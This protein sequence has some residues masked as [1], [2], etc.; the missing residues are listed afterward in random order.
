MRVRYVALAVVAI[1]AID[2]GRAATAQTLT[3]DAALSQARANAPQL[4]AARARI[5][6]ARARLLGASARF[7]D[8]PVFDIDAGPRRGASQTWDI[9]A[10]FGQVFETGGQ[11]GARIAGAE[12]EIVAASA[13]ADEALRLLTREVAIAYVRAVAAQERRRL[14]ADAEA[15]ANQ[16]LQASQRRYEAG[17]IAALDLNLTRIAAARARAELA[18]S[19]ADRSDALRPLRIALGLSA[20]ADVSLEDVLDR[21]PAPAPLLMAA[22][23]QA[24]AIRQADAEIEQTRADQ[25]LGAALKRPDL[26]ARLSVSREQDD[27]ILLGGL[28]I[29][30]PRFNNGQALRAEAD[31]RQRRLR[32][33]RD[34]ALH[35]LQIEVS[36][37]LSAYAQRRAAADAIRET[38]LPAADDNERLAGRSLDAGQI[39]LMDFLLVRQ[40]VTA[41]RL[42]YVD[43][44]ADA[45]LAAIEI[46][47]TAGVLR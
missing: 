34:A 24:P 36:A 13:G 2:V 22:L 32:L 15:S 7:R 45:A 25:R 20:D 6:E 5:D 30:L 1:L 18:R 9:S 38:A 31:A 23:P 21:A 46:E 44:L 28:S 29:T 47:A 8:N 40:D 17:D 43:A 3:F 10:G 27:H 19:D 42:A 4:M 11:R 14:L 39:N 12:A 33:E 41:A 35:S 37:G 16:L 26:G